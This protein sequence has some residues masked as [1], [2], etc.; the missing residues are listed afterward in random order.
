MNTNKI[1]QFPMVNL[2]GNNTGMTRVF[3][4]GTA[5]YVT[6]LNPYE[7]MAQRGDEIHLVETLNRICYNEAELRR[8]IASLRIEP[9]YLN[10]TFTTPAAELHWSQE[11]V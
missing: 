2:D 3:I 1:A 5:F 10:V 7:L 4:N 11:A 6:D 9:E 8:A